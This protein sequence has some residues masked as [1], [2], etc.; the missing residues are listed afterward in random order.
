MNC[1]TDRDFVGRGALE[2][3]TPARAQVGLRLHERGVLRGH[4]RVRTACGDGEITSGTFSPTLGFSIALAR[5]PRDNGAV[6]RPGTS[7]EVDVRGRWLAASIVKPPFVR[8]GQSLLE[9]RPFCC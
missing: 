3:Q 6:P 4:M 8:H 5:V 9:P 1:R 2:R 7:V